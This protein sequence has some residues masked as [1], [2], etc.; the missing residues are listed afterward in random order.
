MLKLFKPAPP[1]ERLPEDQI[2]SEYKKFRLQVFLGIGAP[3]L[4]SGASSRMMRA[5]IFYSPVIFLAAH[6]AILGTD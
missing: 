2:D 1:I 3:K 5:S 4:I 6:S